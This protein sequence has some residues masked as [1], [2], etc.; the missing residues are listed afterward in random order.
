MQLEGVV[1]QTLGKHHMVW[2]GSQARPAFPG[3]RL[4]LGRA[5]MKNRVA[6]GDRVQL[7]LQADGS[8]LIE[9]V[10]PRRNQLSRRITFTGAEHVVAANVDVLAVMLAPSPVLKTALLDRYL[11][12][13]HHAKIRPLVVVNKMDLLTEE[14]VRTSLAPYREMGYPILEM[15]ALL[16]KGVGEFMD[17]VRGRWVTLVGHSGV[18]KS[19]LV[20]RILPEAH[21]PVGDV[22]E[23][24]GRGRHTT[25]SAVA[26]RLPDGTALVDTAGI[27]E[28]AL[29]GM[30][31]RDIEGGFSDIH[32]EGRGCRFP[33][34]RHRREPD[35]QV[36]IAVEQGRI[37]SARYECYLALLE[38]VSAE[39]RS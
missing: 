36:R 37:S 34:C 20:N 30:G 13:A 4:A 5:G 12:A 18:G 14:E 8:A 1:V 16:G 27:R 26:Y 9:A 23:A 15:S 3:G 25:S 19:T 2:D 21:A 17:S 29:W 7:R 38:E 10:L 39:A 31:E 22:H 6:V 35:C 33:D 11:V 32:G 24:S 28:F